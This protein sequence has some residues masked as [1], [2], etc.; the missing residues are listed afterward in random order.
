MTT[1]DVRFD[2]QVWIGLPGSWDASTWADPRDW[3][4]EVAET[5]WTAREREPGEQGPDHLALALLMHAQSPLAGASYRRTFLWL[6]DPAAE[7][8]AVHLE[9]Y[10]EEGERDE[11]LRDLGR[12]DPDGAVEPPVVEPFDTPG[13]GQGLR[14]L[15]YE[16][17]D[18]GVVLVLSYAFR[19]GGLDVR[20]WL[21]S[22]DTA[23]ALR[24]LED[25]DEL[26]RA[27]VLTGG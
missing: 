21:S 20:L 2:P 1:V 3:A 11:A 16:D 26:A 13:L 23:A 7:P 18:D 10:V 15:R 4:R 6:P 25:V 17:T 22:Y 8:L 14:V 27:L 9:G 19:A 12:T 24:A 5:A